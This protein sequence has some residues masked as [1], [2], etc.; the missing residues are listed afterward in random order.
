M[1]NWLG[2]VYLKQVVPPELLVPC[3]K[4]YILDINKYPNFQCREP[5]RT[6]SRD[7]PRAGQSNIVVSRTPVQTSEAAHVFFCIF[8]LL[9]L[10]CFLRL[11]ELHLLEVR[12]TDFY[13][14]FLHGHSCSKESRCKLQRMKN[15]FHQNALFILRGTRNLSFVLRRSLLST[16]ETIWII[17]ITLECSYITASKSNQRERK[18]RPMEL[19]G[20]N[21]STHGAESECSC[22]D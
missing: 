17:V 10:V 2:A 12:L 4:F 7:D 3:S 15:G 13:S 16:F 6:R 19:S 20:V 18:M 5:V 22:F 11:R 1:Y 21:F 14:F 9:S 8:F